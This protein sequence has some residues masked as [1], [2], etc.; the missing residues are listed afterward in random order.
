MP[1]SLL[2]ILIAAGAVALLAA[3]YSI[4]YFFRGR[5]MQTDVGDNDE[6]K[7]RGLKCTSRQIREDE[8]ALRGVD[9]SQVGGSCSPDDCETCSRDHSTGNDN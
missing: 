1:S 8:A 4:T 6:M 7:K 2:V 9:V 3:G 5:H